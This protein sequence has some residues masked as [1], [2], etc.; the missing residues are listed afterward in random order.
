MKVIKNLF[1]GNKKNKDSKE[2]MVYT[3]ENIWTSN[4]SRPGAAT[5]FAVEPRIYRESMMRAER[6]KHKYRNHNRAHGVAGMIDQPG[7]PAVGGSG[8]DL[9]GANAFAQ[10]VSYTGNA[11]AD[12]SFWIG[13]RSMSHGLNEM[14]A[15]KQAEIAGKEEA[16]QELRV[17]QRMA[18][19]ED[20]DA[21][22]DHPLAKMRGVT[23]GC[24][25]CA[26]KK[27]ASRL[28]GL[29]APFLKFQQQQQQQQ[30]CY[31]CRRNMVGSGASMED[32]E[33][34]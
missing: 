25:S 20:E 17:K 6:R 4:A 12:A 29:S 15:F 11:G 23:S 1:S 28:A 10:G 7:A 26:G 14:S 31:A 22:S 34:D 3:T 16:L 2:R 32:D 19:L 13:S 24:P 27:F 18:I 5:S 21:L 33:E 9:R 30:G 8:A